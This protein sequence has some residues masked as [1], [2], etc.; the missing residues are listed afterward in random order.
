MTAPSMEQLDEELFR[1]LSSFL[2]LLPPSLPPIPQD[3]SPEDV[4]EEA[5][6]VVSGEH[7]RKQCVTLESRT[8]STQL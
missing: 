5:F 2:V 1:H 6:D 7:R 4:A 3:C 8:Q